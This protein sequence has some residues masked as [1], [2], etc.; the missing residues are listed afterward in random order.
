MKKLI[1]ALLAMALIPAWAFG[2]DKEYQECLRLQAQGYT[3]G[4]HHTEK[5][6]LDPQSDREI[7]E[8]MQ[9][10]IDGAAEKKVL[11]DLRIPGTVTLE[12]R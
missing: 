5:E 2:G 1:V 9:R 6:L 12:N 11:I 3:I 4:C 8:K 7:Y 10:L